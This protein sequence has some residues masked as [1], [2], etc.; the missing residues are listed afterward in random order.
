MDRRANSSNGTGQDTNQATTGHL[1]LATCIILASLAVIIVFENGLVIIAFTLRRKLRKKQA[2]L[3]VCSQAFA[4]LIN[5]ILLIP[6][7]AIEKYNRIAAL[8][9]IAYVLYVS[10]LNLLA[11]ALDRYLALMRP[12]MHHVTMSLTRTKKI[13]V[14]IW[15]IPLAI[16]LIPLSWKSHPEHVQNLSDRIYKGIS[17]VI[18]MLLCAVMIVVYLLVYCTAKR[19]LKNR[20]RSLQRG[21]SGS[22]KE[23]R[24]IKKK[25][26][27]AT[28]LFGLLL[29]FFILAYIPILYMNLMDVMLMV[30]LIPP[31]L[32][33]FSLYSLI[34]NSVVNPILCIYLKHDYQKVIKKMMGCAPVQPRSYDSSR[35]MSTKTNIDI[36]DTKTDFNT[37]EQTALVKVNGSEE[38]KILLVFSNDVSTK[39]NADTQTEESKL[40]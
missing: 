6:V 1:S 22:V 26:L 28:N 14:L 30:D 3:L 11:L 12:I 21:R 13:I 16:T 31:L 32:E 33:D 10:V 24:K 2:N 39:S 17:W 35:S 36:S 20:E 8:Y 37:L 15:I 27:R 4:D 23:I 25:Q 40:I 7:Y 34:I 19:S 18:L 29:L 9:V 5:G 38:Q